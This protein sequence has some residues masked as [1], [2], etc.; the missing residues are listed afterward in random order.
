M[1][2]NV[3]AKESNS[4]KPLH[5]KFL[6]AVT[7]FNT[8][9]AIMLAICALT[10]AWATRIGDLHESDQNSNYAKSRTFGQ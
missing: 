6:G 1:E 9:V 10:T 7:N 2:D 8:L 4:K 3:T 5:K